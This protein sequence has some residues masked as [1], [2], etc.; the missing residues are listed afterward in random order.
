MKPLFELENKVAII[1]G[2]AGLLGLKHAEAIAEIGG[3]PVLLDVDE[4]KSK[5]QVQTIIDSYYVHAS[6]YTCDITLYQEVYKVFDKVL[7]KFGRIDI[8]IN[9]AAIDSKVENK[10]ITKNSSRL[11]NLDLNSWQNEFDV[12][13]TGTFICSYIFGSFMAKQEHG[14]IINI[15]SDLAF[16][17]PNQNIYTNNTINED[18][19]PVKPFSYSVVKHSIVGLS[20]Y[21]SGRFA[22][23]GVRVNL[24]APGGVWNKKLSNDFVNQL[25]EL[26]PIGRMADQDDYKGAIQFLC[27]DASAYMTGASLLVDGGKTTGSV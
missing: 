24:L 21:F 2:G 12:G 19:R 10:D 25:V 18:E 23:Y 6:C 1:T 15:G 5:T 22:P 11:E 16:I 9:N 17:A 20:K 26:I 4:R 14:V 7:E 3:I 13:V 27:S 8:L